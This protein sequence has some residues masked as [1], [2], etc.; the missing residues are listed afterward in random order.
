[1]QDFAASRLTELSLGNAQPLDLEQDLI[2]L[3]LVNALETHSPPVSPPNSERG[4][5]QLLATDMTGRTSIVTVDWEG[6]DSA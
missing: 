1:M 5:R 2:R 6:Q 4:T 3:K